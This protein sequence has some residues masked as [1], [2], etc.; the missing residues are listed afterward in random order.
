MTP[1]GVVTTSALPGPFAPFPSRPSLRSLPN[2][3]PSPLGSEDSAAAIRPFP[4]TT[5]NQSVRPV[6]LSCLSLVCLLVSLSGGRSIPV[7]VWAPSFLSYRLLIDAGCCCKREEGKNTRGTGDERA[8]LSPS[9]VPASPPLNPPFPPSTTP[10]PQ[11]P[12]PGLPPLR[13]RTR[14]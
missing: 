10:H 5:I 3:A 12:R 4:W 7:L 8:H 9:P 1:R 13:T 6:C 11:P 14:P 2:R